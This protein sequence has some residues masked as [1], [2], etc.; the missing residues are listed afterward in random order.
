[1]ICQ[2][3]I[4]GGI[5]ARLPLSSYFKPRHFAIFV[6]R[7]APIR[8]LPRHNSWTKNHY[9]IAPCSQLGFSNLCDGKRCVCLMLSITNLICFF[10]VQAHTFSRLARQ[11]LFKNL[12]PSRAFHHYTTL[13]WIALKSHMESLILNACRVPPYES[14]LLSLM[15]LYFRHWDF[16][17]VRGEAVRAP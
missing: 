14:I 8:T 3:L 16:C 12:F 10:N 13:A 17:F 9:N 1:M 5:K 15:R 7:I 4:K 11:T 2:E 6:H